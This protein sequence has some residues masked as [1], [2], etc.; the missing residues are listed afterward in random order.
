M[1]L[2]IVDYWVEFPQSEYGGLV[3]VAAESG[4]RAALILIEEYAHDGSNLQDI[5]DAVSCA[6]VLRL[7][8]PIEPGL[9]DAFVT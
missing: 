8:D 5:R 7:A 4:E 1:N 2:Y 3:V 6:R 9:V